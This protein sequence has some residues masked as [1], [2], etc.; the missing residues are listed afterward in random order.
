MPRISI[1]DCLEN[2]AFFCWIQ[3]VGIQFL[4]GQDKGLVFFSFN[5]P[6]RAAHQIK[7]ALDPFIALTTMPPPKAWRWYR[8]RKRWDQA[9]RPARFGQ[10][11][12]R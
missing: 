1:A 2:A 3:A 7:F 10:P 8:D 9:I 5:R 4:H 11:I 6:A 12:A